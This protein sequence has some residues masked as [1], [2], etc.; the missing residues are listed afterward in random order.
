MAGKLPAANP[1]N[2]PTN[3]E[4]LAQVVIKAE[5]AG[6]EVALETSVGEVSLGHK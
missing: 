1:G 3:Y 4:A 5:T 2:R 6:V